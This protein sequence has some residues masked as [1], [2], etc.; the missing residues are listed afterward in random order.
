MLFNKQT[1]LRSSFQL[2]FNKKQPLPKWTLKRKSN[3]GAKKKKN[4]VKSAGKVCTFSNPI[5]PTEVQQMQK[6]V[7]QSQKIL[8]PI[9]PIE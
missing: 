4:C 3:L 8:T 5:P 2:M 9:P 6:K 1:N 7:Q